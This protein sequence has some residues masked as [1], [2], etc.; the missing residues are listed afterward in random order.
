MLTLDSSLRFPEAVSFTTVADGAVLLNT[1]TSKYFALDAVG[2]RLLELLRQGL[3][4]RACH[5]QLLL[6]YAVEAAELERDLLDL[7]VSLREH[8][9]VEV[10]AA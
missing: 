6:E 4:L 5:A 9:L 1:A 3:T 7:V 10:A 8:G 2:A